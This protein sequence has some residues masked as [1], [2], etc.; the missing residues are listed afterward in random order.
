MKNN[1]VK[2]KKGMT[3]IEVIISVALLAIL[4][5]PISGLVMSSLKNNIK[6]EDMQKA[7]YIGQKV[8]EELK[9]YDE[10]NLKGE[11]EK[12]FELLDG[13][14]IV[15]R[16]KEFL[17]IFDRNIYGNPSNGKDKDIY[18]VDVKVEKDANFQYENINNRDKNNSASFKLNF[19]NDNNIKDPLGFSYSISNK[20]IM[21]IEKDS[22]ILTLYNESNPTNKLT[23]SKA[24]TNNNIIFYIEDKFSKDVNIEFKNKTEETIEIHMI[25]ENSNFLGM[26]IY[27]SSGNTI[28]YEENA[29]E[30]NKIGDMYNYTV[31]V[32][33]KKNN[34]LFQGMSNN[35][36]N[37]E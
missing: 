23:I 6:S 30:E 24:N 33:D 37:I 4:I 31:T 2:A 5:I 16:D 14:K 11:T 12:Y 3:L 35:N 7:S 34:I 20:L 27:S 32:M 28:L 19:T 15:K 17:E 9:S 29:E 22:K 1:K 26:K 36:V 18:R 10:I 8:L 21:E 25:K 13:D